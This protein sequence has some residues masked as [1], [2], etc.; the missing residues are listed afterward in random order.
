[1]SSEFNVLRCA[2]KISDVNLLKGTKTVKG[3]ENVLLTE[4]CTILDLLISRASRQPSA[5][6]TTAESEKQLLY[7]RMLLIIIMIIYLFIYFSTESGHF[8]TLS[9]A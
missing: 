8:R 2:V 9:L 7:N 3:A 5:C 1:M 6:K 4:S